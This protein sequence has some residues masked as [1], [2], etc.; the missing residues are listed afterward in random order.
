VGLD[1]HAVD[2]FEIDD[3]DLIAHGLDQGT[4]TEIARAAQESLA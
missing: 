4:Q 2:L 3:P 1:E